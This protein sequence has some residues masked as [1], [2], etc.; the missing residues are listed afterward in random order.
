MADNI[1]VTQ[2]S[3]TVM[4]T[5]D[6]GGVQYPR[7][8]LTLGADNS[9]DGDV[10]SSNPMPCAQSGTWNIGNVTTVPLSNASANAVRA[11]GQTTAVAGFSAV[12]SSVLDAFFN[13]PIVGT[14]VTYNQGSGALN[15]VAGTTANAEFLARSVATFSGAMRVRFAISASQ[16]IAN[17]NFAV[18]MADLL[19]EGLSYNIVSSTVVDV[20]LT[21][22]GFNAT[23]VGQFINIGGIT[24]AAGVPGRYAIASLPDANTIRFTVAGW[25]ATG[26]GTCSLF[27]RNYIRNLFTGTTATAVALDAQRNG[28]ASGDTTPTVISTASPGLLLQFDVTGREIFWTDTLRASTT[29]PNTTTR[30][31]RYENLPDES[32]PLYVFLWNFNGTTAPASST[33]WTMTHLSVENFA[34]FPVSLES[35]RS[36][37]QQNPL[38]VVLTSG[39]TTIGSITT[40]STVTSA[41]LAFPGSVTDITSGAITTTTTTASP[42]P[43][44]GVS[45]IINIPVTA[46]SGTN[47]TLDITVQESD[48]TATSWFTVYDFP[49]ITATGNYRSPKL[50]FAG[51]RIR[52]IQTVGGTTPS[53]TRS[54]NRLQCSDAQS[55]VRQL[56]DRT[57]SL[58]T[59]DSVTPSLLAFNC[60]NAML[61]VNIGAASVAPALT[62]EGSDDNGATWY[63][64]G[65]ALTAVANS[66]VQQTVAARSSGLLRARV[67]TAGTTV[68]AGYVLIKGF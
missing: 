36:L 62:L 40:V 45:Y 55:P 51:N 35:V 27:G 39:A 29:T 32:L 18:M 8:K 21:A 37:G 50:S 61:V 2:G 65:T 48:D 68:T 38:P 63:A 13:A 15:V 19:G 7:V 16:R 31:S 41:S 64:V 59:L 46:V 22:H 28:W 6:V 66:T 44:A 4:A 10:S 17:T 67:S 1:Q 14:G 53:F 47:P 3:G 42:V 49:R 43:T 25:P 58:T 11:V 60:Q 52:F 30:A 5:D 33:T 34:N 20:T 57:I 23:N 56:I 54:V 12:G 9:A 24:G 26:T